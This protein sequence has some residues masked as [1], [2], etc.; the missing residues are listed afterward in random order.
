MLTLFVLFFLFPFGFG[1]AFGSFLNVVIWRLPAGMSLSF[2][3]SHCPKCG[4]A[5]RWRHNVPLLGWLALRGRCFDCREPISRRYPL[6]ELTAGLGFWALTLP[7]L[8]MYWGAEEPLPWTVWLPAATWTAGVATL[9][10]TALAVSLILWDGNRVPR[11]IFLPLFLFWIA[12]AIEIF[13]RTHGDPA[14]AWT[15]LI[16]FTCGGVSFIPP[17]LRR[18]VSMFLMLFTLLF[19]IGVLVSLFIF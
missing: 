9:F 8:V 18:G 13:H 3:A 6:V 12:F 19:P 1:A 14:S 10:L 5:I 16:P 15:F 2:P 17:S 7:F 4:R 11:R